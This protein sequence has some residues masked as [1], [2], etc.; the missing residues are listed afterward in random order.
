MVD[1]INVCTEVTEKKGRGTLTT[2]YPEF[3]LHERE[4]LMIRGKSFYAVWDEDKGYWS[5]DENDV[6]RIGDRML[7]NY[8]KEHGLIDAKVKLFKNFTSNSWTTW[9]KYYKSLPDQ[10]H[11]LDA[12]IMFKN[13]AVTKED[14]VTRT[15]PYSLEEQ[16]IP[17]YEK[18]MSTLYA[19][20]EREKLEWAI[21]AI[22]TGDSK[23]IQKFI[24]LYGGPGTG[25][26]T[27]LNIIQDLF[28]GYCV[29]FD[30]KALGSSSDAFSLEAFRD[31]PLIAIQ[32]DGDLSKIE[33]NTKINSIV[34]HEAMRIN[35]K[36]KATYSQKLH[37]F[38]FMGTNKPVKITDAKSGLIRR[39]ID[40]Q[41][42]GNVV[43][44]K[45]YDRLV[46]NIRFELGGIA[47]HCLKVYEEMG[48]DFYNSYTPNLM[49]CTTNDFYNFIEDNYELFENEDPLT[50][51]TAWLRYK[52]YCEDARVQYP[53]S[54][55]IFRNELRNYYSE[56]KERYDGQR[57]V[58]FGF[59]K[60]KFQ[61]EE[62]D[63]KVEEICEGDK[64]ESWLRFETHIESRFDDIFKDCP[65]QYATGDGIPAVSWDKIKTKLSD[66][67]PTKL[68]YVM[69]PKNLIVIDFDIKDED[70]NKDPVANL[71]EAEKWPETYAE[72]SKSQ[73][74][75][76]LHY[77]YTGDVDELKRLHSPDIEIK[78]Y[79]GRATLRRM[80]TKCNDLPIATISSGLPLKEVKKVITEETIKSERSLRKMIEKN[81]RKEIHPDTTSSIHFI[82][83]LL[84]DAYEQGLHYDVTDMRDDIQ[85]F[86]LRSSHQSQHCLE[87]VSKM[88][89]RSEEPSENTEGYS[90]EAP[91]VFF[92][93]EVFPNLFVVVLKRQGE[94]NAKITLI[95]PTS[96]QVRGLFD[97][98]LVGYNNRSYDNHILYARSMGYTNEE[99][100][101]LSQRIIVEKDKD[102]K[103]GEAYNLSYTDIYDFMNAENKMSLKKWEIKL[104]IHHMELDLPWDQPVPEELWPKVAEYCGYDVDATEAVWNHKDVQ[105]D[106]LAREI[107]AEWA[108]MTVNDTTNSLT[109]RI[110]VGTDKNPKSEYIYTD[111]STIFPGYEYNKYGID[112]SKYLEGTK[113]VR[114]KSFYRGEDPG[115]G[116]Y[117]H[118]KPGIWYKVALLDIASMHPH[119]AIRLKIFGEKY[120]K[121]LEDIVEGRVAIKH[122]DFELAKV[123]LPERLWKYL[124]DKKDAKKLAL[125]LKTAINSVYGLTSATFPNKLRDPRNED[126]IVAK[127]GALFM[128]NLKHEVEDRGYTV[129]HIKTDSI[130][131]ANA[132]SEIIQFVMD[133]G[134]EYGYTF[135]HEDTYS[136]MCLVNDAVYI[137]KYEI[138]HIDEETGKEVHWTA[139]GTQ[140]QIPYVFKTLFSKEPITFKDMCRT[141]TVT[142]AMYL[143]MCEDKLPFVGEEFHDR[144]FIGKVGSF[145]PIKPGCGGGI[146][147]R[148]DENDKEKFSAVVGTKIPGTKSDTYFWLEEEQFKKLDDISIID[149]SYWDRLVDEA[150]ETI[151][152]YG[153][154]ERFVAD[155]RDG[156]MYIP[157]GLPDE[158]P[159]EEFPMNEPTA[160]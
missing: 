93:V 74:G 10:Y 113:I 120:T 103:F 127:Y 16:D 12:K 71:R 29:T 114:G 27:V 134:K 24:V 95:N 146:L 35:E 45:E 135:E 104:G 117:V 36:F 49:L 46:K 31:N 5:T 41:P 60:N 130:K 44:K 57:S 30:S 17:N 61:K 37:T 119:S 151:S 145:V 122:K 66:L 14:Y 42:S 21:G 129:V 1:F 110:I 70:G 80:L 101:R 85:T 23:T 136:K 78:V 82:H 58:Y 92:D 102:A 32:H 4:D 81:L 87:M 116:G 149:R 148:Q 40:V 115:E 65:A 77:Y 150:V 111:L 50:L 121:R 43:P 64:E 20:E 132:D 22:I 123:F 25:K 118:A 72:L 98:R 89:F 131:I 11:E 19:P 15:L 54:M 69:V 88:P 8:K 83:K 147:V 152:K 112:R 140:F 138:P 79:K 126:N 139:T 124:V 159:F 137:A 97:F 48:P 68:H 9:Q 7:L 56:F 128:I 99:L 6:M 109:T 144:R 73:A 33:D 39:L 2:I 141:Q 13:D 158:V 75:I 86:A 28:S 26:S 53:Y 96:E 63:E 105:A 34:S 143:D 142:T 133:Y 94:G 107:L 157:D 125:A 106:F 67:D 38:L 108:G 3:V 62:D 91:I 47:Y 154:F 18:L 55:R 156:F 59:L 76:H 52:E 84:T 100:F 155:D 160:A 153:D 90:P 51:R